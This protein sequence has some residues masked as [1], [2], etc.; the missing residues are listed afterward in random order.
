[1]AALTDPIRRTIAWLAGSIVLAGCSGTIV[2]PE[3]EVETGGRQVGRLHVGLEIEPGV[4][5]QE[6][7]YTIAHP[8]GYTRMGSIPLVAGA[9]VASAYFVL[10]AQRN[11]VLH[12]SAPS[13]T[14][15]CAGYGHFDVPEGGETAVDVQMHCPG[16]RRLGG[17]T[18]HGRFNVCPGVDSVD[19][20]VEA[21]IVGDTIAFH[22]SASDADGQPSPLSYAWTSTSGV[23]SNADTP[24]ASLLCTTPGIV[25][26]SLTVS[27]GDDECTRTSLSFN[28][29]CVPDPAAGSAGMGAGSA[30][31]GADE[32]AG[33]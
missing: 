12:L 6:V 30:G 17:V 29:S 27:D 13:A 8:G 20:S 14:V 21:A 10:P 28:V 19:A 31:M 22:G 18:F 32:D 7:Q 16:T 11:Y 2:E 3:A 4:E 15:T 1:M 26:V 23:L 33:I 5:L 9:A 24:D 25:A